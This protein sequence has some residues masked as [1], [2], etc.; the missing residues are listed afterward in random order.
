MRRRGR[1]SV[2]PRSRS[3]LPAIRSMSSSVSARGQEDARRG[4]AAGD[5]ADGEEWLAGQRIMRFQR[6]RPAVGHEEFA[7]LAAARS[8]CGRDRRRRAARRLSAR[9]PAPLP[10]RAFGRTPVSLTGYRERAA[11]FSLWEKAAEGRMRARLARAASPRAKRLASSARCERSRRKASMRV[12]R[13]TASPPSPRSVSTTATSLAIPRFARSRSVDDHAREPRRQRQARDRAAFVGD[14][15]VAID[16]ADRG[17]KRPRLLQRGERRGSRKAS[18]DG[19]ATP[20]SAQ[21]SARP[22]RSAERISGA[23]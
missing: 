17:Q 19:S 10:D 6:R 18:F 15:A 21:S 22:E 14:A 1:R 13:S 23:A 16:G 20:Q 7:A 2:H 3:T 12:A 4:G 5:F 8:R 9:P 11:P